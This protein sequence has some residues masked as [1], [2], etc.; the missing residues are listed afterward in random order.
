MDTAFNGIFEV[1]CD[2]VL[3]WKT[4][5]DMLI[6]GLIILFNM[7]YWWEMRYTYIYFSVQKYIF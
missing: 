4:I 7:D 5:M 3:L 6:L 2:G 1:K